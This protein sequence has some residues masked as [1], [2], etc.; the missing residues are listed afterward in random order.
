MKMNKR[1]LVRLR[2]DCG[3]GH[4]PVI[5]LHGATLLDELTDG[6]RL[7]PGTEILVGEEWIRLADHP[8]PVWLDRMAVRAI[9]AAE[10]GDPIGIER[11]AGKI[12]RYCDGG[13]ADADRHEAVRVAK[14]LLAHVALCAGQ[15]REAAELLEP[16]AGRRSRFTPA[17]LNNLGV[18]WALSLHP[19]AALRA[20]E[21]A[22]VEDPG[23]LVAS[24]SLRNLARTLAT[25]RAPALPGRPSWVEIARREDARLREP[26]AGPKVRA[27]L[28]PHRPFPSYRLWHVFQEGMHCP[29]IGSQIVAEPLGRQ[30]AA[31]L[32]A[33]GNRAWNDGD[34]ARAQ[35]LA[36]AAVHF[37]PKV[38]P[39]AEGLAAAAAARREERRLLEQAH[40]LIDWLTTFLRQLN[41]LTL[42][43]LG[44]ARKAQAALSAFADASLLEGIY[45]GRIE[46]LVAAAVR[47]ALLDPELRA[48]LWSIAR[49]FAAPE[50]V[51]ACR[52]AAL[53]C[54]ADPA[55]RCFWAAVLESGDP[56]AAAEALRRAAAILG[57][58]DDL[59]DARAVLE[60]LQARGTI[61]PADRTAAADG[62]A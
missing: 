38:R 41:E 22:L 6:E 50:N 49:R 34:D 54:L 2:H 29:E 31:L 3:D 24:L 7:G 35:V 51:E 4:A 32:L 37:D 16:A 59:A 10:H 45:R 23:F 58:A 30:A 43:D 12:L 46:E 21:M 40:R 8:A 14:F 13:G 11:Y 18:A 57:A 61:D 39:A 28:D 55:V 48:R 15:P 53:R 62:V 25:E 19:E 26:S 36:G 27:L 56:T 1:H 17:A 33:E 5:E 60:D 47:A 9:A 20:F 42:D 44:A 52:K